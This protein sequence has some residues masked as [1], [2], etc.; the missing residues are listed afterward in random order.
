[1]QHRGR[2]VCGIVARG[3]ERIDVVKWLGGFSSFEIDDL[4]Q[5]LPKSDYHTFGGHVR[6]ATRGE[7][8]PKQILA[9]GHPHV[10]GGRTIDKG[11]HVIILDCDMA[12][13]H[14]GQVDDCYLPGISKTK[15]PCDT[16]RLLHF[17]KKYGA[18]GV[19][20]KIPGTY[21]AAIFD[22][23]EED[24]LLLR[25]RVGIRPGAIGVRKNGEYIFSSEDIAFWE[26]KASIEEYVQPG[27]IYYLTPDGKYHS[28]NVV[29]VD[30]ASCFF[31]WNYI[32]SRGSIIDNLSVRLVRETLGRILA[33]AFNPTDADFVTYVPR[34]P[35]DAARSFSKVVNKPLIRT[36]YKMRGDRS[37]L[38]STSK[39][40]EDCIAVN[41]HSLPRVEAVPEDQDS[42]DED[43][44]E[45][46]AATNSH[47]LEHILAED[48]LDN[49]TVVVI[50]DSVVRGNNS[51]RAIGLLFAAGIKKIYFA[52]Y[53]PK[54]GIDGRFCGD[55]VDMPQNDDFLARNRSDKQISE[56]VMSKLRKDFAEGRIEGTFSEDWEL[57]FHFME[58]E[59]MLGGFEELRMSRDKLCTYC[60][61][62]PHPFKP[63]LNK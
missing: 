42:L 1:V 51:K 9:D 53:T 30:H 16:E 6:Y 52:S 29:D 31:E 56:Y 61:A 18:V 4:Q 28:K 7:K 58:V 38:A 59:D 41:L 63:K 34:C 15:F 35:K 40:R 5:L 26:N 24:V 2:E 44:S 55:G 54:I 37:F 13:I 10:I 27:H 33:R 3:P 46:A 47:N 14:N 43:L 12:I 20:E 60:I 11:D 25:D 22:K 48:Y 17:Y 39:E 23:R 8:D 36:F 50:D 49:K 19:L 21:V 57:V 45:V 62:R 32:A